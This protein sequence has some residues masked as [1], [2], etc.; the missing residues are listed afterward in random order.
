[1]GQDLGYKVKEKAL[2]KERKSLE[3]KAEMCLFLG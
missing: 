2:K 3:G 1:M